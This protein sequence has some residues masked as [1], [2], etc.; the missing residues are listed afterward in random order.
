[1]L[2]SYMREIYLY[3]KREEVKGRKNCPRFLLIL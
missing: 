3:L 2:H 1:L